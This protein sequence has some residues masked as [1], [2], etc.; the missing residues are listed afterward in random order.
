MKL[1]IEQLKLNWQD[2]QDFRRPTNQCKINALHSCRQPL[3][4][5]LNYT[6]SQVYWSLWWWKLIFNQQTCKIHEIS[7]KKKKKS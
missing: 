3:E 6:T 5:T 1:N 2:K 4:I 7:C